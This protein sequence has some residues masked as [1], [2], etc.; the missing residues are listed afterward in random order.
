[1]R[2]LKLSYLQ[3][4][5][6]LVLECLLVVATIAEGGGAGGGGLPEISDICIPWRIEWSLLTPTLKHQR[7]PQFSQGSLS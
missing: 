1:M 3:E 6:V 7:V 4:Q 2:F 5:L